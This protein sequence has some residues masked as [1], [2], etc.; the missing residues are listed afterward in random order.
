[1]KKPFLKFTTLGDRVRIAFFL[2][3]VVLAVSL[4]LLPQDAVTVMSSGEGVDPKGLFGLI[5]RLA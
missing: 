5:S 1:M 3:L 4:F 2:L